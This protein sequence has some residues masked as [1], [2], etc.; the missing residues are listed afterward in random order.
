M[1]SLGEHYMER[2]TVLAMMT[3]LLR[4]SWISGTATKV[5]AGATGDAV[6]AVTRVVRV[7]ALV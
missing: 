2:T 6:V 1:E 3:T 4:I 7:A 5:I